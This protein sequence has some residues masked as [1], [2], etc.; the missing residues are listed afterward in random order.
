[1]TLNLIL[2][3]LEIITSFLLEK[4]QEGGRLFQLIK[5]NFISDTSSQDGAVGKHC[6]PP[7]MTAS[8]LQLNYRT[9][10]ESHLKSSLTEVLQLRI[11]RRSHNKTGRM[12]RDVERA[13]PTPVCDR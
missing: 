7:L 10:I 8:K 4:T 3:D 9:T 12:D 6:L 1:M 2:Y 5:L 11:Y 13:G